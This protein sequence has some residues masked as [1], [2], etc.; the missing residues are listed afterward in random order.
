VVNAGFVTQNRPYE[1]FYQR[2][3]FKGFYLFNYYASHLSAWYRPYIENECKCNAGTLYPFYDFLINQKQP[4]V[5]LDGKARINVLQKY[6]SEVYGKEYVFEPEPV[7]PLGNDTTTL[8]FNG[9]RNEL[10]LYK[11]K[12]GR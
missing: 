3:Y 7:V 11:L 6:L 12:A 9:F 8:K 2:K 5:L 4:V 1:I 10:N